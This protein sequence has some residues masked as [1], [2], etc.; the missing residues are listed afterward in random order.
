MIFPLAQIKR[1]AAAAAEY[2]DTIIKRDPSIRSRSE[3]ALHPTVAAMLGHRIAHRFYRRHMYKAAR[4][5]SLI[6]RLA[7]GGIEI[8]PGAEIGRR[9][10]VDHGCGVVIGETAIIGDDVTLFHQVTLGSTGWW[11][12]AERGLGERRHPRLGDGVTVGAN[13]CVLGPI[14]IGDHA[15]IGAQALVVA[16]VPPHAMVHA[17]RATVIEA[18]ASRSKVERLRLAPRAEEEDAPAVRPAALGAK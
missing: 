18:G 11:N 6:A 3:A 16:D 13:A 2:L 14:M 17:P 5:L 4:A 12:D 10:F 9:F 1:A 15:M 7:S 8:H